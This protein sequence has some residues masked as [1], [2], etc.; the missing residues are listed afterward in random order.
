MWDFDSIAICFLSR[1]QPALTC[2]RLLYLCIFAL[3]VSM[4]VRERCDLCRADKGEVQRVEKEDHILALH[5]MLT[6][7]NTKQPHIRP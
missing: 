2:W 7:S 4:A 6:S 5:S 1:K 3:E